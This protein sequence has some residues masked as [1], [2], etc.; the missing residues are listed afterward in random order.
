MKFDVIII[1][2]GLAG[3]TCAIALQQQGKQCA[4]V[5]NGQA[6][7]DF[8]SG[9]L[10]LLSQLPEGSA[11]ENFAEIYPHF[12]KLLPHHPYTLLGK[13]QVLAK[14]ER[15]EQLAEALNLDL[16]GSSKENHFRV[17]PLGGLRRTWLSAN[18]VPTL[19]L[20]QTE[21]PHKR[22]AVL[23]IE[24]YHDFQPQLLADN[25]KQN[26][27][28]AHCE[29]KIG[30]LH[31]PQLDQLR[32]NAREFRSVNIS[33]VLE[34]KL[35]FGEL[36]REIQQAAG[37]ASAVF[38]PACFGMSDNHFFNSLKQATGLNLFEL[39]TLPP[40]L[41]GMRQRKALKAEFEKLGGVMLNG[42]K[43]LRAEI[44][45]HQVKAL[46][47]QLHQDDALYAEHFVLASGHYFSS[48]IVAEFDRILEPIFDLDIIGY[49]DF[50]NDKRLSWTKDRFSAPQP[51]QSAGVKINAK[52]Q[53]QK[54]GEILTNL[55]AVGSV[56][57][58]YN[59]LELGCSSGVAVVTALTVAE[60]ILAGGK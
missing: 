4:I 49:G 42:D 2:G 54:R 6:A 38:L 21:F 44:I 24:G 53:V 60:Q 51:Y 11:V 30:Y 31:I 47:T 39:P 40:S 13:E 18:S 25:L 9:S 26:P 43:A 3:L 17:T 16:L 59:N 19:P 8:S 50:D 33:Q 14:A 48:G 15:F 58:G 27:Q 34:H 22:I 52:C 37:N 28:F 10:D 20:S 29:V 45:D 23:G 12:A 41:L 56:I 5:N 32:N 7:M 57:G 1:G 46:Y 55:Y 36:V 35:A